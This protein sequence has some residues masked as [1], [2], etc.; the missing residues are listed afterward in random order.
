MVESQGSRISV[1]AT[2]SVSRLSQSEDE[3][4]WDG[5]ER[6]G[7][8]VWAGGAS[9]DVMVTFRMRTRWKGERHESRIDYPDRYVEGE[10]ERGRVLFSDVQRSAD[11]TTVSNEME[12]YAGE[13]GGEREIRGDMGEAI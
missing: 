9:L 10:V 4:L 13:E 6:R 2:C 7:R 11:S 1:G 8:G 3:L 12:R 5:D